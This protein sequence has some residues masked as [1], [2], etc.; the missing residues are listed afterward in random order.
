MTVRITGARPDSGLRDSPFP[1]GTLRVLQVTD[2]HLYADPVGTLLGINTL[3]SFRCVLRHFRDFHWPLDV[4]LATGDLVHD[5]S[6]A[7]YAQIAQMLAGFEVPVFCL[8]GNHDEPPVMREHLVADRVSTAIV[9]D[10]GGWRFVMLDTVIPGE[11]GGHLGDDQLAALDKAL[12]STDRHVLV[13]MHHQPVD[14][15]STWI[16]TMTL[17]NPGPLFATLDR[18]TN[19]RGVLWGHV[20]QTFEAKRNGVRLMASPSTC[21]QFA[22]GSES[23]QVDEEP[24]GF[25]LLALLP[26]GGIRSEVVRIDE[27]PTGVELASAGY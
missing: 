27:M 15:G 22:P 21:V 14:V 10:F 2:T 25:R 9:N 24:P 17:D 19:V 18:H 20:H 12:A 23:F 7:G 13:C 26:D 4:M 6:P 16:D 5:A 1:P 8:P 11:E 3:D